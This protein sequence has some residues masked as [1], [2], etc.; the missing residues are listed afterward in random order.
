LAFP[1]MVASTLAAFVAG[2]GGLGVAIGARFKSPLTVLTGLLGAGLAARYVQRATAP[3]DRFGRAFGADWQSRIP[4]EKQE[5]MLRRRWWWRL[6]KAPE[7]RWERD[8]VF[9]TIPAA[10]ASGTGEGERKLLCDI[11]Q[12]PANVPPSGLAFIYFHGSGWHFSDKDVATRSFF[13]HLAAQG[14]VVMDVA[15]RLCPETDLYGMVGDVR[16][17]IVWMKRNAARYGVNPERIVTAGG[18]AGGHLALLAA[19]TP[20]HP[21]LTPEAL[22]D[23]DTS[24]CAVVAYYGPADMRAYHQHAG[25]TIG[26]PKT[27]PQPQQAGWMDQVV[28]KVLKLDTD[29]L[30]RQGW[31]VGHTEMMTNLLG[32]VPEEVPEIYELASP[33]THAGPHCPPTLLFQGEHD[34]IV[35]VEAARK[36]HRRLADAG[37]PVIYVEFPQT[38]H[39]FDIILP[40]Y[41]P[42]AQAALYDLERFLALMA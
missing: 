19:Y 5:R 34:M 31:G 2:I 3:H 8:V 6:P 17:A 30:E 28:A 37:V 33:I 1:K 32:G 7:P 25:R 42:A 14:H 40:R 27:K 39:A 11:W 4:L 38:E 41:A 23:D 9:W 36:L 10:Q 13:R 12:P 24:V 15:Y 29:E 22:R 20:G 21:E 35:P 16:R 18:S 26:D